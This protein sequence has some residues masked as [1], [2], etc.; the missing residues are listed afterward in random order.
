MPSTY[1]L[2][3]VSEQADLSS[4]TI[5]D[6][7][8]Y[9]GEARSDKA[10]F[11]VVSKNN[12][13]GTP[14]YLAVDNS[15]P[16]SAMSWNFPT[17]IPGWYRF[18]MIRLPLY[19]TSPI[20]T[21]Q[22][23]SSMGVI[24]QYATVVF[25][26][27]TQQVVK[28]LTT[29]SVSVQPGQGGWQTYWQVISDLSQ[30]VDYG[31]IQVLVHGDLIDAQFRDV[32]RDELDAIHQKPWFSETKERVKIYEQYFELDVDLEGLQ[33]LNAQGRYAEMEESAEIMIE[34]YL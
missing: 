14:T 33:S 19:S 18:N 32:L 5:E 26:T 4:A 28:A 17:A 16:V 27:P 20:T 23:I 2:Q 1:K 29:G 31:A 9:V 6:V 13:S 24:T 21:Q 8:D 10:N 12:K 3:L 22:E 7:S 25:H 11:L 34:K 30:L 15:A